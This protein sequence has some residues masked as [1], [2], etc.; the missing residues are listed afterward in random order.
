METDYT[1]KDGVSH[2][3]KLKDIARITLRYRLPANL[4]RTLRELNTLGFK[5]VILKNKYANPTPLG[6][7]ARHRPGVGRLICL[8]GARPRMGLSFRPKGRALRGGVRSRLQPRHLC[9]IGR[10]HS[11]LVRGAAQL[12]VDAAR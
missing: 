4:A 1:D 6:Y 12:G 2:A 8:L 10:R 3:N 9:A 11:L 5:I 7:C